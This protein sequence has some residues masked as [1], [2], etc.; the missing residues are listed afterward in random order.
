[1]V[2][3]RSSG[4]DLGNTRGV[5][6]LVSIFAAALCLCS[7]VPAG[8]RPALVR[9]TSLY[10]VAADHLR[11]TTMEGE[12]VA[13]LDGN[14]RIE[15][16]TATITSKFGYH[17]QD[18]N[19]TELK[20]DVHALDGS[21][22]M[23]S[24]I[25]EYY[26]V[27]M[28][29]VAR[30]NVRVLDRG[31]EIRCDYARYD[32]V[33][34]TA[35]LTGNLSLRDS[36]RVMY[37]DSIIYDRDSETAEALGNVVL[38]DEVDDY[39]I[40]GKHARYDRYFGE[41]V[42]D[43]DPM[44]TFDLSSKE[45]GTI[46]AE[47]MK[48]D[49]IDKVGIAVDDVRL[50]K[51]ETRADCD[52]AAIFNEEGFVSLFGEPEAVNGRSGMTGDRMDVYYEEDEVRRIII[53]AEGR[54]TESPAPDSPW[55]DDSWIIGDSV[56]IFLSDEKVDSVKIIGN[57]RAM[58]Y[59]VEGETGKVSNNFSAGD[60]MFFRFRND[61]LNYVRMSGRSEGLYNFITLAAD[62]TVDSAAAAIDT[63]LR[64]RDFS[65]YAEKVKYNAEVIEYFADTEDILLHRNA[66]L[67]Y[68]NR[69]LGAQR[70]SFNSRLNV[71]E[72]V[73]DPVME[74]TDQKMYGVDM[75][76][77]MEH[78]SGVVVDGSTKYGDGYYLGE[79]IFKVGDDVLKVY[80]STYT[81]CDRKDSHYCMRSNRMKIYL[82]DKIVSGP[83][84]LFVGEMP[85]FY[86]PYMAAS[87]R[88]DRHSG[89]LRPNF[90]VGISSR[91]GRFIRGLGYY[92]A[93][94]DYTDFLFSSDFNEK[95][96]FRI[97]VTNVY[98]VRYLLDGNVRLNFY[99]NMQD[100]TNEWT[101]NSIHNQNIGRT[102]KFNSDLRFVS[103]DNA[104]SAIDRADD[105][106]KIVDR[107]IYSSARFNKRW[108]GTSFN[109]SAKRDQKLNVNPETPTATKLSTTMPS[110]SM[111]FPRTS[112]WFGENS[113]EGDRGIWER[114]LG[115][116]VFSP[117]ISADRRTEESLARS[118]STLSAGTGA[119]LSQSHKIGFISFNP[120]VSFNWNYFKVLSDE[121]DSAYAEHVPGGPDNRYENEISSRL[122]AQVATTIYGTF[123][124]RIG[125]LAGI[126]HS[127]NPSVS[128]GFT[129]KLSENQVERQSVSYT[130]RNIFDLKVLEGGEEVK[131][132]NV[133]AWNLSGSYNP[134][135]DQNAR[136][137][138][139][140]SNITTQVGNLVS[141][142][143]SHTYDPYQRKIVS[144]NLTTGL[145]LS[146]GGRF[147]YPAVWT[148]DEGEALRAAEDVV[149]I[150]GRD[151]TRSRDKHNWTL[152]LGYNIVMS[153]V[154][155]N[156]RTDS[157]VRVSGN[158][159]LTHNWKI[160]YT[161]YYAVEAHEFREQQ[162]RI[163]RDLHCWKAS[164]VHRRFG[165]EWSYY[166][167]I[168]IKSHPEI[169]YERGPRGLQNVGQ[170]W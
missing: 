78:E 130:L 89:L 74:E 71:L 110:I 120:A 101:I 46:V 52:S 125:P 36:T 19:Y 14:V 13:L 165:N 112:L 63:T 85:I 80:N 3:G 146:L 127:L 66:N 15:H 5:R 153:G 39:S 20:D 164:F 53:P 33:K 44:L 133:L 79:Y 22:E 119:S 142:R 54:L 94:S 98:K 166:F 4:R 28:I 144:Q 29:L 64:Y 21:M 139:I 17:Y 167:Q 55:R 76:Y 138:S 37:A 9:D 159:D 23:F 32:R 41:A 136:F 68:Q 158:I 40:A 154:E 59:P 131:K 135:A 81:T 107:R 134:Q 43:I 8:R 123:Y 83:I 108:G 75:G 121:I 24:D 143:V 116:I 93:T 114:M 129:P 109:I 67:T 48:F 103:S 35:L 147:G 31:W 38:I 87:L 1:M 47:W 99:R 117:R 45:R 168:A 11:Y 60:T 58:Y 161:A 106:S 124:P 126:R 42:V 84:T 150:Q 100:F 140:S 62:Q 141:F 65:A 27:G 145:S 25:G 137:S 92:W 132:S 104:Q 115:S 162:Y 50:V 91:E 7:L 82:R 26:G 128:Y 72:A 57:S 170:F 90:D 169:M 69:R 102:A 105:V 148:I 155:D 122:S 118:K 30:G 160:S 113:P 111:N 2:K 151:P 149:D 86:L 16:Q 61:L 96:S 51:G 56:S 157:N 156:R 88:R 49:I 97:H 95:Q 12:H 163:E 10:R 6:I 77:H 34:R 152:S 70:I 18:K 73:G